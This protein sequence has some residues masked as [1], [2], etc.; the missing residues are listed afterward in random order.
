M[1]VT[2]DLLLLSDSIIESPASVDET[3]AGI[4]PSQPQLMTNSL[5]SFIIPI[6]CEITIIYNDRILDYQ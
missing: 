5:E 3:Y 1:S 4:A 6:T 2:R